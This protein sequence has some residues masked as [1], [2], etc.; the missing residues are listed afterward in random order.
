MNANNVYGFR[1]LL[2][3]KMDDFIH[4][5]TQKHSLTLDEIKSA[6]EMF[7]RA[8]DQGRDIYDRNED[9][10]LAFAEHVVRCYLN[11]EDTDDEED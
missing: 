5:I 11:D 1:S 8:Y 6:T 7:V 4:H 9:Q 3:D 2:M 10:A